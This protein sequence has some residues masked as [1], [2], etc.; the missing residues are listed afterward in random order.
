MTDIMRYFA[1]CDE[2]VRQMIQATIKALAPS[3]GFD[4]LL[5]DVERC[6]ITMFNF[7]VDVNKVPRL[8]IQLGQS[9][10]RNIFFPIRVEDAAAKVVGVWRLPAELIDVTAT[11]EVSGGSGQPVT[12]SGGGYVMWKVE[13]RSPSA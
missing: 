6:P 7:V 11:I 9:E 10:S 8:R 5:L 2:E 12:W 1:G 3:G 4:Q 13:E